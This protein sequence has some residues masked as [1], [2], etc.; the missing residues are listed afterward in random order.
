MK[1]FLRTL[2][3]SQFDAVV[4]YFPSK[5]VNTDTYIVWEKPKLLP[6]EVKDVFIE[7]LTVI[8]YV[9]ASPILIIWCVIKLIGLFLPMVIK[10]DI[11]A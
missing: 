2:P 7:F 8:Y 5:K 6:H 3:S 4:K 9:I 11:T 1:R 10:K